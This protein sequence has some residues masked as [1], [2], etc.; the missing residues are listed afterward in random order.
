MEDIPK[1]LKAHMLEVYAP[2]V[3]AYLDEQFDLLNLYA[4][5]LMSRGMDGIELADMPEQM[6]RSG[7][8]LSITMTDEHNQSQFGA[9][10]D[11]PQ[12]GPFSCSACS[13]YAPGTR[14]AFYP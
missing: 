7:Y 14:H 8:L 2:H 3:E 10:T 4:P 1:L 11:T 6:P 13:A 12:M 5:L 9:H